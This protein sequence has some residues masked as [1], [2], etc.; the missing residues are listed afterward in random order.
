M[1]Q[2]NGI[3]SPSPVAFSPTTSHSSSSSSSS[4][5]HSFC[6]ETWADAN[7]CKFSWCGGGGSDGRGG[8]ACP[9]G[10]SCFADTGC[11]I[12]G[13]E[14][15]FDDPENFK[16]CGESWADAS[17]CRS[18]WCGGGG[19]S[20]CP[21]GQTCFA[22]TGCN[23]LDVSPAASPSTP[24]R[25][26]NDTSNSFFCG[27]TYAE[28]VGGCS[29]ETHCRSGK[30]EACAPGLHCW[31]GVTCNVMDMMIAEEGAA[32]I[33]YSSVGPSAN[34]SPTPPTIDREG[35]TRS[36]A[37]TDARRRSS[38]GIVSPG[39][40]LIMPKPSRASFAPSRVI[41]LAMI[42]GITSSAARPGSTHRRV[43]KRGASLD[44][45]GGVPTTSAR[46]ANPAGPTP[47]ATCS[48]T[49]SS[50]PWCPPEIRRVAHRRAARS[51]T[52]IRRTPISAG[53]PRAMPRIIAASKR[54]ARA[55]ARRTVRTAGTA[56]RSAATSSTSS[57]GRT[58]HPRSRHPPALRQPVDRSAAQ[59]ITAIWCSP[60]SAGVRIWRRRRIAAPKHSVRAGIQHTVR[61]AGT[62][63][64][65]SAR[66]PA[67]P[68][69]GAIH[70][71]P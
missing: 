52:T 51:V 53:V 23:R 19:G 24:P 9:D 10:Q 49:P 62:A 28:A 13:M 33:E 6:G 66:S 58:S 11:D 38:A 64:W 39:V 70:R 26:Y 61:T 42:R 44:G 20:P 32:A 57:L 63:G 55:G 29:V 59:F 47:P 41:Q 69:L 43:A 14:E 40:D 25:A 48:T 2:G 45:V 36:P 1:Q 3:V 46:T 34:A 67:S 7:T 12:L 22:D 5:N 18:A 54:T 16:F 17:T 68:R 71:R 50:Q 8:V 4:P 37:G 27:A 21:E 31:V 56:G 30:S 15:G 60:R 65:S 35:P